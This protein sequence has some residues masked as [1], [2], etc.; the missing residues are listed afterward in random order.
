[1]EE[2][3]LEF[4]LQVHNNMANLKHFLEHKVEHKPRNWEEC[5]AKCYILY[6]KTC[7]YKNMRKP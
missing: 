4:G 3:G 5:S 7:I 6:Q 1:M 2:K